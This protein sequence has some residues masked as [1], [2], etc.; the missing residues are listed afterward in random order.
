MFPPHSISCQVGRSRGIIC[1]VCK[2]HIPHPGTKRNDRH[3]TRP[4][5]TGR[6]KGEHFL[7]LHTR[8]MGRSRGVL[9]FICKPHIPHPGTKRNE[10]HEIP[11]VSPHPTTEHRIRIW[12]GRTERTQTPFLSHWVRLG[13]RAT[14]RT[15][16]L[17]FLWI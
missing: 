16:S 3:E 17:Y 2:P 11:F 15:L 5:V 10:R 9:C 6:R 4:A 8:Q 7:T 12:N 13:L 1:F 14:R